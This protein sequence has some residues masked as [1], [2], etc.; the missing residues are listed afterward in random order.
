[1]F[2][3]V[4]KNITNLLLSIIVLY[5]TLIELDLI[6]FNQKVLKLYTSYQI[7]SLYINSLGY[8]KFIYSIPS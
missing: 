8:I 6:Q 2:F 3:L 5:D 4:T 7:S 1:M